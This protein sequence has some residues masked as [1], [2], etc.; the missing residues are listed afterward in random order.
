MIGDRQGE[1]LFGCGRRRDENPTIRLGLE[2]LDRTVPF[3]HAALAMHADGP[4][5]GQ[6][7]CEPIDIV[8]EGCPDDDLFPGIDGRVYQAQKNRKLARLSVIGSIDEC[9]VRRDLYQSQ[10]S[11]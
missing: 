1:S 8:R 2:P 4:K 5:I 10:K 11:L 7:S 3:K 9:W 6:F